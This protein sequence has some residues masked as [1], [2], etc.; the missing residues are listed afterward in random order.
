MLAETLVIH[1]NPCYSTV[2]ASLTNLLPDCSNYSPFSHTHYLI[3]WINTS[4]VSQTRPLTCRLN[5]SLLQ[6][7][8]AELSREL[9]SLEEY[10]SCLE[11][12]EQQV[13][14][15]GDS[16][17]SSSNCHPLCLLLFSLILYLLSAPFLNP[18]SSP[19][20]HFP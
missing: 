12:A 5:T 10:C 3:L 19:F 16:S 6:R 11:E 18:L 13:E 7:F 17:S 2:S 20:P 8:T 1:R 4:L 14:A 15:S 9:K